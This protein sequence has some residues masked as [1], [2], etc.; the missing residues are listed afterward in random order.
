M[1]CKGSMAGKHL[2]KMQSRAGTTSAQAGVS[3]SIRASAGA[4]ASAWSGLMGLETS[5]P[6]KRTHSAHTGY[7]NMCRLNVE[8]ADKNHIIQCNAIAYPSRFARHPCAGAMLIFP[9]PI[10]CSI[11]TISS[12][13]SSFADGLCAAETGPLGK[14]HLT[15]YKINS[16]TRKHN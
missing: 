8:A 7:I 10:C 5:T 11:T 12:P 1:K 3:A 13:G 6:R 9:A 4:S 15:I 16:K 2:V 14:M